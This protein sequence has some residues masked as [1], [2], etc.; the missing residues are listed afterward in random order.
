MAG[1][2]KIISQI[3]EDA[4]QE[5]DSR[6]RM[7]DQEILAI[8]D[9][10]K[11]EAAKISAKIIQKGEA[12][13]SLYLQ[14][15]QSGSELTKRKELLR[16]KQEII[17]DILKK[18]SESL[19]NLNTKEYFGLMERILEVYAQPQAGEICFSPRDLSRM[20]KEFAEKAASIAQAKG[21]TL[22]I[23]QETRSVANGFVLVYGMIE[24]NCTISAMFDAKKEEL[25]DLMNRFLFSNKA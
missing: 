17:A 16:V 21:G 3:L 15:V 1:L 5:A 2:E 10:A 12:E 18:S 20:P 11:K 6:M 25:Q 9:T 19:A 22:R 23:S 13:A 14:K 7:A 24:E 8:A 4:R